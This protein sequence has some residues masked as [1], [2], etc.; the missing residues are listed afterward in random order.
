MKFTF[1]NIGP[2]DEAVLD[3]GDLTII[4][5]RNNTG[6]TYMVYTLYGFLRNFRTLLLNVAPRFLEGHFARLYSTSMGELVDELV[7]EG[8]IEWEIDRDVLIQEQAYL[9]EDMAAEYAMSGIADEFNTTRGNFGEASM[10]VGFRSEP[11]A[12]FKTSFRFTKGVILLIQYDGSTVTVSLTGFESVEDQKTEREIRSFLEWF[13]PFILV[14]EYMRS[15]FDPVIF[16]S[17]RLSISLFY[18]ELDYARSRVVRSLQQQEN[19]HDGD[20]SSGSDLLNRTSRYA[21]PIHDNIDFVREMPDFLKSE[22]DL[23][24]SGHSGH[25]ER[26]LGGYFESRDEDLRFISSE[27]SE[28]RFDIPLH[29]ASSSVCEMFNLYLFLGHSMASGSKYFLIID[30]PESHLDTANQIQFARLIARLVNSGVKTLITTHSDY[31]VREVNNLILL[32][33][34][35]GDEDVLD[36]IDFGYRETDYLAKDQVKA[37][38]AEDGTLRECEKDDYGIRMPVFDDTI[39]KVNRVSIDLET[40]LAMR[41]EGE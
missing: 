34:F 30:E 25:I 23:V 27:G 16:S 6:K 32:S 38:I 41:K 20:S 13:Y 24:Q 21:Q 33:S 37:Y 12:N 35:K 4:A 31:I 3:L 40:K 15:E 26:M 17:A 8:R 11:F 2:I 36:E 18:K 39:Q 29:L 19:G 1:R 22:Q 28:S 7:S 14:G 5:G 10:G 9:I